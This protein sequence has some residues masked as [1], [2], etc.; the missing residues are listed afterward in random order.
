MTNSYTNSPLQRV[1]LHYLYC[2]RGAD[3]TFITQAV[4]GWK[5]ASPQREINIYAILKKMERKKWIQHKKSQAKRWEKERRIFFLT[6][7]GL[8]EFYRLHQIQP[9]QQW[10]T[11]FNPLPYFEYKLYRHDLRNIEHHLM[12]TEVLTRLFRHSQIYPDRMDVA[13]NLMIAKKTVKPDLGFATDQK[14]YFVEVDT[15]NERGQALHKKFARYHKYFTELQQNDGSLPE[16]IFFVIPKLDL[17]PTNQQL[18]RI[19]SIQTAFLTECKVFSEDVNLVVTSVTEFVHTFIAYS[20]DEET[21]QLTALEPNLRALPS[22]KGSN[23]PCMIQAGLTNVHKPIR[24][25][26]FSKLYQTRSWVQ[27]IKGMNAVTAL[28]RNLNDGISPYEFTVDIY[29]PKGFHLIIPPIEEFTRRLD[30]Q[31]HY[32]EV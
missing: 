29:Y 25:S 7:Q 31:I 13:N 5:K 28:P 15:G 17:K 23:N 30:F 6:P 19:Q 10:S 9:G 21:Q 16:A 4:D 14:E 32:K 27:I 20:V 8:S 24:L 22:P 3:I 26:T 18:H 2:T 1:I 12:S 11:Y